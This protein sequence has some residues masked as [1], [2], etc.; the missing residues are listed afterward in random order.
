MSL[1]YKE[2]FSRTLYEEM[3]N[4]LLAH[5]IDEIHE[6]VFEDI[7]DECTKKCYWQALGEFRLKYGMSTV[8]SSVSGNIHSWM[9]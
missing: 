1:D 9:G 4:V 3:C 8:Y 2:L 5:G 7:V 6:E